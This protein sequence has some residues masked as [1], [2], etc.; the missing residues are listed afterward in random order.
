M[1]DFT[2]PKTGGIPGFYADFA[3]YASLRGKSAQDPDGAIR[4]VAEQ[5]ESLFLS[6]LLKSMRDTVPKDGLF[7][8]ADMATYQQ[9]MDQQL[10]LNL[11]S[12][13]GIGLADLIEQQLRPPAPAP[14]RDGLQQSALA[15][16][17][18][19]TETPEP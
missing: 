9:M 4:E 14:Q 5:F 18:P 1:T 6:Q 16:L 11:S 8:S 12:G 19:P 17:Q 15:I 2:T 7:G 3:D 13:G 10:A